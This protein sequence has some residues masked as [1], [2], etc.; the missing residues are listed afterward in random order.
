[1]T[2][3]LP[4]TLQAKWGSVCH[5][6]KNNK[7]TLFW[8]ATYKNRTPLAPK[9]VAGLRHQTKLCTLYT[10]VHQSHYRQKQVSWAGTSNY[11]PQYLWDVITCPCPWYLR[12]HMYSALVHMGCR[13]SQTRIVLDRCVLTVTLSWPKP[14]VDLLKCHPRYIY[15]PI[16]SGPWLTQYRV[17][18]VD[19]WLY[20][21]KAIGRN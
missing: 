1:M 11:I 2:T 3:S 17:G 4:N 20:L 15:L 16:L 19:R 13:M 8:V 9:M 14:W 21:H 6:N 18:C 7:K 12:P 10:R 5:K